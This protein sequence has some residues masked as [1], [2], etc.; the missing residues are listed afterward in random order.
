MGKHLPHGGERQHLDVR[1]RPPWYLPLDL[2]QGER[3]I[4]EVHSEAEIPGE[5]PQDEGLQQVEVRLRDE[6]L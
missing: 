5:R 3:P 2:T 4:D 6:K 1:R